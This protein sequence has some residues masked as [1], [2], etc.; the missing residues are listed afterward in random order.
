MDKL[1]TYSDMYLVED[2]LLE[3]IGVFTNNVLGLDVFLLDQPW[4]AEIKPSVGLRIMSYSDSGGWAD[5]ENYEDDRRIS[6]LDLTFTVEFLARSGRP[7]AALA[8]LLNALRGFK[9]QR[10]QDLY[11]KG[12]G[13][14]SVSNV[15]P[16][17]TVFDGNETEQRARMTAT[18]NASLQALDT[19]GPNLV[20]K[21]NGTIFTNL[22]A[23]DFAYGGDKLYEFF[24]GAPHEGDTEEQSLL[25]RGIMHAVVQTLNVDITTT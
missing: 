3:S 4:P 6:K 2:Y 9:E 20:E 25:K 15:V 7:M 14:L 8:Y 11:S 5:T 23:P 16:A 10:Y 19:P 22:I 12:I 1:Y 18:F 17:N 13:T 21:I 24:N